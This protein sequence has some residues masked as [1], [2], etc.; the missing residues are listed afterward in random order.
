M[1]GDH[2]PAG[3]A[4]DL[5]VRLVGPVADLLDLPDH[6]GRVL[7][8]AV[9]DAPDLG[10]VAAVV[11][12]AQPAAD[13]EPGQP[14]RAH[15]PQ[16]DVHPRQLADRVAQVVDLVDLAAQVKVQ[17]RQGVAHAV[18]GQVLVG[19]DDLR[20]EQAELAPHAPRL[21][22]AAG[23]LAAELDPHADVRHRAVELGVLDDQL[24]LGQLLDDRHDVAP[25]LLGEDH[26]LDEL[27]VLEAVADDRRLVVVDD[28]E[29]RQQL[30][31]AAGLEPEAVLAAEAV[32][33]LDDQPRLVDL[34]R[35][36]APVRRPVLRLGDLP[37]E[38][39]GDGGEPV[40]Q[41]VGEPQQH[42]RPHA[43]LAQLVHQLPQVHA[44]AVG[45]GVTRDVPG[46]VDA[47]V[48][49]APALDAVQVRGVED[50]PRPAG[51][52]GDDVGCI[53]SRAAH[54]A[55]VH[56]R[57]RRWVSGIRGS[58]DRTGSRR[59]TPSVGCRG[60]G[61]RRPAASPCASGSTP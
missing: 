27:L 43:P 31:L 29:H 46:V 39:P 11:V 18:L 14:G 33:V 42:R 7:V 21:L 9:V 12:D 40:T 44:L 16:L 41:D 17:H 38:R 15:R 37:L 6:V 3:L 50:R 49:A 56:D 60:R 10:R 25:D 36:D 13:V 19:P 54:A 24:D 52:L 58:G 2:R 4:D 28:A 53:V 57:P 23:A 61:S 5:R 47:E 1:I 59:P 48:P 35:V 34:D 8:E 45:V 22:P 55:S 30:R 32:N 20:D 51:R 26:G